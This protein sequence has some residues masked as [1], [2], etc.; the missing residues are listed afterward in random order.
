MSHSSSICYGRSQSQACNYTKLIFVLYARGSKID[1]PFPVGPYRRQRAQCASL[2]SPS[3]VVTSFGRRLLRLLRR[4]SIF[5]R[6]PSIIQSGAPRPLSDPE[7]SP[8]SSSSY[9]TCFF[10]DDTLYS[11]QPHGLAA[12]PVTCQ[13]RRSGARPYHAVGTFLYN[14]RPH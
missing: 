2:A 3:V 9:K 4:R 12:C 7:R 10:C 13:S 14:S 6:L 5:R 11:G 8:V 1:D